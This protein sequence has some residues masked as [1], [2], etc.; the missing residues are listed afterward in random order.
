MIG[1][2]VNYKGVNISLKSEIYREDSI[3]FNATHLNQCIPSSSIDEFLSEKKKKGFLNILAYITKLPISKLVWTDTKGDIWMHWKL[4]YDFT[5]WLDPVFGVWFSFKIKDIVRFGSLYK[6]QAYNEVLDEVC[7]DFVVPKITYSTRSIVL[8][9]H[10]PDSS[11][12]VMTRLARNNI[13][14]DYDECLT[15]KMK[16]E[17][18]NSNYTEIVEMPGLYGKPVYL[19]RWTELG[20]EFLI[21]IL[22]DWRRNPYNP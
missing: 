17:Y 20:K 1:L 10:F 18:S 9:N 21:S 3:I 16:E 12:N 14:Q 22:D 15:W 2:T 6:I 4:A 11:Q 8:E 5:E 13:I 19:T 7:L